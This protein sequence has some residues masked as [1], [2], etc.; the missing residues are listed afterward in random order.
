L[1]SIRQATNFFNCYILGV[2]LVLGIA[3]TTFE[4]MKF[5]AA[6]RIKG[7]P[8]SLYGI[9]SVVSIKYALEKGGDKQ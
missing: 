1:D 9:G 7:I 8:Y 3:Y 5:Y 6:V 4:V 2:A